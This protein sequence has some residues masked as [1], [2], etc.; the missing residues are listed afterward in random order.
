MGSQF[1]D[2][3]H[4]FVPDTMILTELL[5]YSA[6]LARTDCLQQHHEVP[7]HARMTLEYNCKMKQTK[8]GVTK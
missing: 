2:L 4:C 8:I 1:P 6:V 3:S 5:S 7:Q